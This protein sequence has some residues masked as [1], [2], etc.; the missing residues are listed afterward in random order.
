L[1]M[2]VACFLPGRA[3]DLSAPLCVNKQ[4]DY[5]CFFLFLLFLNSRIS[6]NFCFCQEH[7]SL[8]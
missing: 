5:H 8:A 3:K 7:A 1:D 2:L 6:R 4:R